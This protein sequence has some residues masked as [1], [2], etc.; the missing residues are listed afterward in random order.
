MKGHRITDLDKFRKTRADTVD[1][2]IE[3]LD[4][5][6]EALKQD[7]K[8]T[9][10]EV[11]IE[12]EDFT[13]DSRLLHMWEAHASLLRRWKKQKHNGVLRRRM[14]KLERKIETYTLDLQ[15]KQ[16]GQICD[17]MNEQGAE[18]KLQQQHEASHAGKRATGTDDLATASGRTVKDGRRVPETHAKN[19]Q[20]P[21]DSSLPPFQTEDQGELPGDD[22]LLAAKHGAAAILVSNHGGRQL[23]G[24]ITTLEALHAVSAV[25][26]GTS[27]EVYVD[28]G[29]RQAADVAKALAL[30]AKA[31]FIGRPVVRAL[32]QGGENGV[33]ALLD[34]FRKDFDRILALLGC[35]SV[36]DIDASFVRREDLSKDPME[37]DKVQSL[38]KND[39]SSA[40][41]EF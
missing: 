13:A 2:E 27:V 30:G 11:P 24:T 12:E 35:P 3:D 8:G 41:P 21:E 5:W 29:V 28:G 34:N 15:G 6:V 14:A 1:G 16:W 18:C 26:Q 20:V 37:D 36:D 17:R 40:I 9:T 33:A 19:A 7:V 22:A 32:A 23:D 31:A 39:W 38:R 10:V 4:A 25:L